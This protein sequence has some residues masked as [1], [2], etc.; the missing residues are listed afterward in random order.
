MEVGA[1]DLFAF[2]FVCLDYCSSSVS[3]CLHSCLQLRLQRVHG[4]ALEKTGI[5][6]NEDS[7]DL[8]TS[9]EAENVFEDCVAQKEEAFERANCGVSM[10]DLL[11]MAAGPGNT[12][13]ETA[14]DEDTQAG[15]SRIK[16]KDLDGIYS[17]SELS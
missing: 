10:A 15:P 4:C 3:R 12:S 7:D 6:H 16:R 17:S 13:T 11:K 5:I 8:V 9:Q 2:V 1:F 14:A